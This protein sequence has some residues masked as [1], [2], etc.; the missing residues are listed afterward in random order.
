MPCLM[1]SCNTCPKKWRF[2]NP[3]Q[4]NTL[5]ACEHRRISSCHL[6]VGN[7]TYARVRRLKIIF[8]LLFVVY[9]LVDTNAISELHVFTSVLFCIQ[10]GIFVWITLPQNIDADGKLLFIYL[11][12]YISYR[13]VIRIFSYHLAGKTDMPYAVLHSK[14]LIPTKFNTG[15][16]NWQ[17]NRPFFL[18]NSPSCKRKKWHL[19]FSFIV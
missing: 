2:L 6:V 1:C 15:L 13:W 4:V 16:G 9:L 10:G 18:R 7:I 8:Y 12:Y 11:L 14:S 3:R 5:L 19:I 17:L